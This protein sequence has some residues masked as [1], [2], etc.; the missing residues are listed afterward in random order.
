M[1]SKAFQKN[2][3]NT[4]FE[5]GLYNQITYLNTKNGLSFV[6]IVKKKKLVIDSP[7]QADSKSA[8]LNWRRQKGGLP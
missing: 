5:R 8:V 3:F 6:T 4:S 1:L 7:S 2:R